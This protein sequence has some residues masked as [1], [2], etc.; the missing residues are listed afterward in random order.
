MP[1]HGGLGAPPRGDS[2]CLQVL[3]QHTGEMCGGKI[4]GLGDD[5]WLH[6]LLYEFRRVSQDCF[7]ICKTEVTPSSIIYL[8]L[9]RQWRVL[10]PIKKKKKTPNKLSSLSSFWPTQVGGMS[11]Q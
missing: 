3:K 2:P 6:Y 7:L 10:A 11:E 8:P 4:T 9:R 5:T 1:R